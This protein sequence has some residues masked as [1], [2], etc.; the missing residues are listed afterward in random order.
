MEDELL[1]KYSSLKTVEKSKT[2]HLA[3][4]KNECETLKAIIE[5]NRAKIAKDFEF[6]FD[7]VKKKFEC[8]N[9]IIIK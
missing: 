7:T 2:E 1:N 9:H 4:L 5:T 3:R 8:E 6:W